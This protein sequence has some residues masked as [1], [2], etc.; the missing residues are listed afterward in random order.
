MATSTAATLLS[1]IANTRPLPKPPQNAVVVCVFCPLVKGRYTAR[2]EI[3]SLFPVDF[4]N[5]VGE[6]VN[7]DWLEAMI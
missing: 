3:Q 2:R 1:F 6:N 7:H 5:L 4:A